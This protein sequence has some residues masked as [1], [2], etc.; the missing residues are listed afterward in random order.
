M[1]THS[2]KKKKKGTRKKK[3]KKNNK[4]HPHLYD[5]MNTVMI[6]G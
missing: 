4:N 1:S 6:E 2:K 5:V 3:E